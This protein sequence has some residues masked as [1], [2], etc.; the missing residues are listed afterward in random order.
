MPEIVHLPAGAF[1][2]EKSEHVKRYRHRHFFYRLGFLAVLDVGNDELRCRH[3]VLRVCYAVQ[4]I[5]PTNSC[6]QQV[7]AREAA[8]ARTRE[9]RAGTPARN[10][11]AARNRAEYLHCGRIDT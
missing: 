7:H 1:I 6:C 4:K 5:I 11:Q 2:G 8:C 9:R 10:R 3:F